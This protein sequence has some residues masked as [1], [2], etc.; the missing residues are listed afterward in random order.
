MNNLVFLVLC[1]L[2]LFANAQQSVTVRIC[3]LPS[4]IVTVSV[5]DKPLTTDSSGC[6]ILETYSGLQKVSISGYGIRSWQGELLATKDTSI[7][8]TVEEIAETIHEVVIEESIRERAVSGNIVH[9]E[10]YGQAFFQKTANAN[11]FEALS[12]V[13]G[14]RPQMNCGICNAGDIHINGMEG[15]YTLMLLDGLP[16]VNG[17]SSVYGFFGIP[18]A[19]IERV[20]VVKGPT[21]AQFGSEAMAGTINIITRKMAIAPRLYA[22]VW[23][24]SYGEVHADVAGMLSAKGPVQS[25]LSVNYYTQPVRW[26]VNR[27]GFTDIALQQRVSVFHKLNVTFKKA[28]ALQLAT[29]YVF[30]DRWGGQK[31][32]NRQWAGSDSV[33]G[34]YIR[35]NRVEVMGAYPIWQ[36]QNLELQYSYVFHGQRSHYGQTQFDA[37][38]H[39]A[40]A[41]LL[42]NRT[43]R[44]K[45]FLNTGATVRYTWYDDNTALTGIEKNGVIKNRAQQTVLPGIFSQYEFQ[46]NEQHRI[47]GGTRLDVHPV[48]GVIFSPRLAYKFAHYQAGIFRI[49]AGRGFRVVNLFT[50][51]HAALTGAREV[52]YSTR[53]NP[54][55]SYNALFS[56]IKH[57][58]GNRGI[59]AT[60]DVSAFYNHFTNKIV[61]DFD[62]DPNKI[63]YDNLQGHAASAGVT[64]SVDL[65]FSIPLRISISGMYN[66]V[67]QR[68]RDSSG[69]NSVIQQVNAPEWSGNYTVQYSFKKANIT[70][71]LNGVWYGPMR[72]PVLP[73]DY[74]PEYSPWYSIM[75]VQATKRFNF[76]LEVYA[77]IKNILNF[78]PIS[79]LMRPHDPFDK[80]VD[81]PSDNPNGYQF[82]AS[83]NYAPLQGIRGF[84]GVRYTLK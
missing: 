39:T 66:K 32:W 82:D 79:P 23:S 48:H 2:S 60:V 72:L 65:E 74:R 57:I 30:E 13:N 22:D 45:H 21:G 26:D 40:F 68:R 42:W 77:G 76:G 67:Y 16:I 58:Q 47:M 17:L 35:T 8:V 53:L 28:P 59:Y 6:A 43:F 36:K 9:T 80:L 3:V 1:G 56:Y 81:D 24:S 12:F 14:I 7:T 25:L 78:L 83:Y 75:N 54:E 70:L 20:E 18:N 44:E 4:K 52:V 71:E 41:Q 51:E 38:Q 50:E 55:R 49:T 15:P 61:A 69:Q 5:N 29:R 27:D 34:E 10:V 37:D 63:I 73:D 19:I 31:N 64:A 46:I 62:T 11:L 33:Y 84:A